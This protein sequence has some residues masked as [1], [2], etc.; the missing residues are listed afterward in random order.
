MEVDLNEKQAIVFQNKK[1]QNDKQPDKRGW[2]K[3]DG[4]V[5]EISLWTKTGKSGV[6]FESGVVDI[7]YKERQGQSSNQDEVPPNGGGYRSPF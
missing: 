7:P 1:K 4:K 3:L 6:Q 5:Y 2:F